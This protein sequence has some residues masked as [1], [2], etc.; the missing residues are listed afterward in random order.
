MNETGKMIQ[1]L[2][3]KAGFTQRTL[4]EALHITDKAISKWERGICLPDVSL[5]PKISL[6]LDFDFDVLISKSIEQEDWGGFIDIQD[7][8]FSQVIL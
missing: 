6:L 1:E 2:R 4:A 5:L 8:D 7:F 3:A